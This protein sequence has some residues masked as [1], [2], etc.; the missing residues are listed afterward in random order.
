MNNRDN[1]NNSRKNEVDRLVRI[2]PAEVDSLVAPP[3]VGSL[4]APALIVCGMPKSRTMS[5]IREDPLRLIR[6]V[7]EADLIVEIAISV[8][9][10]H[11]AAPAR[12]PHTIRKTTDAFVAINE[13]IG[14]TI[15]NFLKLFLVL[16]AGKL[17]T[18]HALADN[19][20]EADQTARIVI[21]PIR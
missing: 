14:L 2:A 3:E 8:E 20:A 11:R 15:A 18:S 16:L 12:K 17:D 6:R 7:A 9:V 19:E 5:G 13:D 21:K 1:N 10:G 4:A